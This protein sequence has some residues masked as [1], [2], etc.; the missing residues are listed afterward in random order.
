MKL[1]FTKQSEASAAPAKQ[2]HKGVTCGDLA[3]AISAVSTETLNLATRKTV[4]GLNALL[5]DGANDEDIVNL[6][7]P[8]PVSL[9]KFDDLL[10]YVKEMPELLGNP[11]VTLKR[12]RA[13]IAN[14]EKKAV[15]APVTRAEFEAAQASTALA[16]AVI[17]EMFKNPHA[18]PIGVRLAI[19]AGAFEFESA[20]AGIRSLLDRIEKASKADSA[21]Q[22][23]RA[24]GRLNVVQN[25]FG[26]NY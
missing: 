20:A 8:P 12:L 17:E 23:R 2:T 25:G 21:R 24:S 6:D 22:M 9:A 26:R 14:A 5:S 16:L 18:G 13:L 3:A 19:A 10:A 15:L 4:E 1:P 7:G 11:F